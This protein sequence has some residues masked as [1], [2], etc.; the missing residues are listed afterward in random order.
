MVIASE[1]LQWYNEIISGPVSSDTCISGECVSMLYETSWVKVMVVRY[2]IAPDICSI[3]V[4]FS[5]PD[6]VIEV[7]F[8][9]PAPEQ[10]QAQ[11][12]IESTVDYMKYLLKLKNA[13]FS[14]GILSLEGI[15]SAVL[16]IKG[17][18]E[19]KL[20]ESLLPP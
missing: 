11:K 2:Q 8:P 7:V 18:P 10:E 14:L 17:T 9:S 15:W 19:V 13:G 16:Q 20:F 3:E 5:F 12:Y 4:E 6:C 1:L